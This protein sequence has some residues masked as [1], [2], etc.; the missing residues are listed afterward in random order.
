MSEGKKRIIGTSAPSNT[1]AQQTHTVTCQG[2]SREI[3]THADRK[4]WTDSHFF[5]EC[6]FRV[7]EDVSLLSAQ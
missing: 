1:A 2:A 6:G 3:Y 4:S 5:D 7:G